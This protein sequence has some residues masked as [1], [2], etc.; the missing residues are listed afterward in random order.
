MGSCREKPSMRTMDR[1]NALSRLSRRVLDRDDSHTLYP[2]RV[3]RDKEGNIYHSV[4]HIL[5]QTAPPE[6]KEA[7]ERWLERPN[8]HQD[9]E[10]ASR[11]G[12][13]MHNHAEY[14]L[15]T[16]AKL[17]RNSA[18]KR[19]IWKTCSDGLE[20]CPKAI[21]KWSL[22][23]AAQTA[24]EIS[25]SSAG[26]TRSLRSWIL[27]RVTAIHA[28]EFSIHKDNFAGTAD[29]LV[30]I[31]GE[32]PF[33]VDWKSSQRE[34]SEELLHSYCCQ[35]GAYHLGLKNLADI[36]CKGAYI[37]VA[38]RTGKPQVRKLSYLELKGAEVSF[39]ERNVAYQDLF[40]NG[41]HPR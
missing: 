9:R 20:R 35:A 11:R 17:A 2:H 39:L 32:G 33:I 6:Q 28:I 14:L 7:L 25:W 15:K 27:E 13:L 10:I 5:S 31:D 18:N 30:D 26:Y 36:E 40:S 12:T 37:V 1:Q 41:T 34:R 4:T 19:D 23:K 29:A 38:M 24:P 21:T 22:E 16:A 3:Y 8:S